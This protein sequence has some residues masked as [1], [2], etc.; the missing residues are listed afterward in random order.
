MVTPKDKEG[1]LV[2]DR[3]GHLFAM[4]LDYLRYGYLPSVS[5]SQREQ[6][7]HELDFYQINRELFDDSVSSSSAES[8][9]S[10]GKHAVEIRDQIG[11]SVAKWRAKA[12]AFVQA[13]GEYLLTKFM[14]ELDQGYDTLKESYP[15]QNGQVNVG[16]ESISLFRYTQ[17]LYL[18]FIS[19]ILQERYGASARWKS[20]SSSLVLLIQYGPQHELLQD[21]RDMLEATFEPH[22]RRLR[23]HQC[24]DLNE[25]RKHPD[26]K[27]K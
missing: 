18:R 25:E 10:D 15:A 2:L 13:H 24:Y 17:S 6:L 9:I 26:K 1:Y 3:S 11:S 14:A 23:V 21:V 12:S 7:D 4:V 5:H 16:A 8:S 20:Y 19:E 22:G 27:K